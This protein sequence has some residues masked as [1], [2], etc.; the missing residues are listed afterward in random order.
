[1]I[2]LIPKTA[3]QKRRFKFLFFALLSMCLGVSI[4]FYSF[5][6]F[7]IYY[8]TPTE[9]LKGELY[10]TQKRYR[11]GGQVV[12]GS[13]YARADH[14]EFQLSDGDGVLNVSFSGILPSLFREESG[15]IAEGHFI[16]DNLFVADSMLAKHDETYKP[17][18]GK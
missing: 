16:S 7:A 15:A 6:Q 11:V 14:V 4:L 1:M 3:L 9:A 13:V 8:H 10:K 18:E 17:P 2:Q 5:K 12:K